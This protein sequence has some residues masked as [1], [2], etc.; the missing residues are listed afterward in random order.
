VLFRSSGVLASTTPTVTNT[1]GSSGQLP[2]VMVAS[3]GTGNTLWHGAGTSLYSAP[4]SSSVSA[5]TAAT[6]TV[7][8]SSFLRLAQGV[9]SAMGTPRPTLF[10]TVASGASSN[11]VLAIDAAAAS[12][13]GAN[14][15]VLWMG[16]LG[17]T[18]LPGSVSALDHLLIGSD[19][20]VYVACPD[21]SVEAWAA[22][23]DPSS[24]PPPGRLGLLKWRSAPPAGWGS[25]TMVG[26]PA[27][28]K[29]PTGDVMYLPRTST[30]A[31]MAILNLATA[32]NGS[33]PLE[34]AVDPTVG[35]LTDAAGRALVMGNINQSGTTQG[36]SI[37]SPT[38]A[39]L[40]DDK[41]TYRP[42]GRGQVLT[43]D[44]Q[45]LFTEITPTARVTGV[46]VSNPAQVVT[47]FTLVGP[48]NTSPDVST[49][50]VV[51]STAQ[52]STGL[53]AFDHLPLTGTGRSFSGLPFP[54]STGAMPNAW[55]ATFGDLQ[56]RNSLKTQ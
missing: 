12:V 26:R 39:V 2:I 56:R 38:G 10:A 31:G 13:G 54:G 3:N 29:A 55:S 9:S 34:V 15:G 36:L 20:T 24:G 35:I 47:L 18:C 43:A 37:V 53:V 23:G 33:L 50:V 19:G 25:F 1:L 52:V 8:T 46:T 21:G 48:G 44:G 5:W 16:N 14:A 45:L 42:A 32:T 11:Y 6:Y 22:D 41:T 17:A 40:F 51:L 7:F 28:G 30:L 4:A 27:I 49:G